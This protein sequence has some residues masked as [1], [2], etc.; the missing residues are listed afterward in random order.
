MRGVALAERP[1]GAGFFFRR[2][3]ASQKIDGFVGLQADLSNLIE[4]RLHPPPIPAHSKT[5]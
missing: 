4:R 3:R 2:T 1:E 5:T